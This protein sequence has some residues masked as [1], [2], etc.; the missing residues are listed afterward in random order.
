MKRF[1]IILVLFALVFTSCDSD[2]SDDRANDRQINKL[3][4]GAYI[5][6]D[7]NPLAITSN[8]NEPANLLIYDSL[9]TLNEKL[10]PFSN[11]AQDMT[12]ENDGR[13]VTITL[14]P[15]V[16]FHDG[17]QLTAHDVQAT[18]SFIRTNGGYYAYNVHSI[19]NA[20]IMNNYTIKLRLSSAQYAPNIKMQLTF[21]IVCRKNL[22]S[23]GRD[24]SNFELNGTGAYKISSETKGKE[25]ILV[26][27]PDYH[28]TFGSKIK[29]IKISLIPD[30][31]TTN[32]L[33]S[34]GILDVFYAP[35]YDDGLKTI[36]KTETKRTDYITDEY[37]FIKLSD[38]NSLLSIKQLRKAI[39]FA[40]DREKITH[41]IYI[42]HAAEAYF[43]LIPAS[44]AYNRNTELKRD[45][46]SAKK[47]MDELAWY[48][49][50]NDGIAEA[51]DY[52]G[53]EKPLKFSMLTSDVPTKQ[54]LSE[55][56][57]ANLKEL[58]ITLE[59]TV[60]SV[61]EFKNQYSNGNYDMYL[62][63]TNVGYDL[64]LHEFLHEEG[65]FYYP[66]EIDFVSYQQKLAS[67]DKNEQKLPVYAKI[68]DDFYENMPH[69]PIL[70][71]KN[72]MLTSNK[73]TDIPDIYPIDLY[74]NLLRSDNNGKN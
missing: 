53:V 19:E 17:S 52:E 43:P 36:T 50:D 54:S 65:R 27:N 66:T 16:F 47:L 34:S 57:V 33:S 48:D 42:S 35:F 64:D 59:V 58:G 21:P 49:T 74:Y 72:T 46:T 39:S 67:T 4:I 13:D 56:L 2:V 68:C 24:D 23:S 20:T 25:I 26:R 7:R 55:I 71:L 69:I 8:F 18:I 61:E 32:S 38:E 41:D 60:V 3:T 73:L 30:K 10:E 6:G 9:Y 22:L 28:E 37:T 29:E 31:M 63:T 51:T 40:I 1:I 15:N 70:F 5:T 45:I 44:W 11:L 14:K 12:I 62:V